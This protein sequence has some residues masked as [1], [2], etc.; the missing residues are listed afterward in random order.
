MTQQKNRRTVLVE[1]LE[2]EEEAEVEAWKEIL[3]FLA[4]ADFL[5]LTFLGFFFQLLSALLAWLF[6]FKEVGMAVVN[7]YVT[8]TFW[9]YQYLPDSFGSKSQLTIGNKSCNIFPRVAQYNNTQDI[10]SLRT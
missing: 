9:L 8:I 3:H 1:N 6:C 4:S 10:T 2:A 7:D 5:S